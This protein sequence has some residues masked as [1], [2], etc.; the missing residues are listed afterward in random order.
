MNEEQQLRERLDGITVPP[1]RIDMAVL[2]RDGRRRARRRSLRAAGGAAVAAAVLVAVPT[3]LTRTETAPTVPA[4]SSPASVFAATPAAP[5]S[6]RVTK[7]PVPASVKGATPVAVDPSGRYIVGNTT[8]GQNFRPLVWTDGKPRALSVP[9]ESVEATSVN[10]SG[11][12]VGLMADGPRTY[13]FRYVDGT[14]TKLTMPK[15]SWNPYPEPAIN[16]AGDIV[17]NAEPS[18]NMEGKDSI[19]LLWKAGS[20]TPTRLP[21]P[22]GANAHDITDDGTIVGG[23]YK[24]G[25]GVAAYAWDQQGKGRKL[26]TPAG[27]TGLAYAAQG[28]WATGGLWPSESPALWNLQT[29]ELTKLEPEKPAGTTPNPVTNGPGDAVNASGWV[30]ANGSVLRD[31]PSL[32][33]ARSTGVTIQPMGLSDTG[34]IVGYETKGDNYEARTWQCSPT[35]D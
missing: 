29:G 8:V 1:S 26:K 25:V 34:L 11:V 12:V 21:L 27:Q 13:V 16:A 14:Y 2:V 15:G 24:D 32:E 20:K 35:A 23:V 5:S 33:L 19:V 18:G 22:A 9:A 28:K 31:G 7:L 6:C 17:I 30:A 4:V 3:I 10:A